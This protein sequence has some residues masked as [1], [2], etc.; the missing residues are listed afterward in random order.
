[1]RFV[2][3]SCR[4]II[5][6]FTITV[7]LLFSFVPEFDATQTCVVL[8]MVKQLSRGKLEQEKLDTMI[9]NTLAETETGGGR[10]LCS[11]ACKNCAVELLVA[12]AM[13]KGRT[14]TSTAVAV[15]SFREGITCASWPQR[16]RK[17]WRKWS[18]PEINDACWITALPV[19]DC[20]V[21]WLMATVMWRGMTAPAGTVSF[22]KTE[23]ATAT[24]RKLALMLEEFFDK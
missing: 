7:L 14:A 9:V 13:W 22:R 5:L 16:R 20:A 4:V 17:K 15:M 8:E 19:L 23:M 2:H 6:S 3:R 24:L 11:S 10:R 12:P 18:R 1:M 21:E